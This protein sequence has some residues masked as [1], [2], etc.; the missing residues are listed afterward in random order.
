MHEYGFSVRVLVSGRTPLHVLA[1]ANIVG[2]FV[3]GGSVGTVA[4]LNGTS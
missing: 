2:L 3:K 4:V 1:E